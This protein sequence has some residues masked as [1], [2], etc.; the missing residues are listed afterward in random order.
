L[1]RY[2]AGIFCV[3]FLAA[4]A[5]A[6]DLPFWGF[7]VDG[8]PVLRQ[9][10]QELEEETS[11]PVQMVVFFLQWPAPDQ[12]ASA[13]FPEE[14]LDAIWERGSLPCLTW[15]PMYYEEGGKE[16]V[17]PYG[18]ILGGRYDRFLENFA[19]RAARW[20]RPFIVRFAHEMNLSRYAWGTGEASYGP[21]NPEIYRRMFRYLVSL[22]R[23]KGADNVLWAFC[24]NVESVPDV[25]YDPSASWNR[26][27]HYY[28]G[29][30]WVD[31]LGMDGYNW[32]RSRTLDR[33][34]WESRWKPFHETFASLHERLRILA[35]EKPVVV[36]ETASVTAG[37]DR[38]T[39]LREA[40]DTA[41]RWNLRGIAW[42]QVDKDNDW[43]ISRREVPPVE[44]RLAP[45]RDAARAWASSLRPACV[46]K[47]KP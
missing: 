14:S 30:D 46:R 24:P 41:R 38:S 16:I 28:P 5:P 44:G 6:G 18:A 25:S 2:F 36:F 19:E 12:A 3:L 45:A 22:F 39:W 26:A 42:F 20:G 34:G 32:G 33:H 23:R 7:A 35:P 11:L 4:S 8:Y 27:E 21:E 43:R 10:I 13:P 15:E 29:G 47:T 37:G 9:T 31:I 40:L 17:I 1:K